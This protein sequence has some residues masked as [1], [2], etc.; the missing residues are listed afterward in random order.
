MKKKTTL[1][2]NEAFTRTRKHGLLGNIRVS[3]KGSIVDLNKFFK[4]GFSL[5][6]SKCR[7]LIFLKSLTFLGYS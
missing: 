4:S 7:D 1:I 5:P 6:G 3:S 2:K